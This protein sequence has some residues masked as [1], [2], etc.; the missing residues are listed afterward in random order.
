MKKHVDIMEDRT[1]TYKYSA[2]SHSPPIHGTYPNITKIT[3][4]RLLNSPA[5]KAPSAS[6]LG[7]YLFQGPP[8][9]RVWPDPIFL[10]LCFIIDI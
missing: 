5:R 8:Y 4:F 2:R 10:H 9:V 3:G 6:N 7:Y 1:H